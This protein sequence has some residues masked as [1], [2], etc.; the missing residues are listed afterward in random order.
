MNMKRI[1]VILMTAVTCLSFSSCWVIDQAREQKAEDNAAEE[2]VD[3]YEQVFAD[4]VRAAHGETASLTDVKC[5]MHES[6][7]MYYGLW[8]ARNDLLGT[9]ELNGNS[10]EAVYYC[11]TGKLRDSVHTEDICSEIT[12]ALP[13]DKSQIYE[14]VYPGY[15]YYDKNEY[16]KI[17]K[18]DSS[19][20]TLDDV[21][22]NGEVGK[23][24]VKVFIFTYEDVSSLT[25][26]EIM[27]LPI[28]AKFDRLRNYGNISI[29]SLKDTGALDDLKDKLNRNRDLI[30]QY[31]RDDI[32]DE[33]RQEFLDNFHL[34]CA[35]AVKNDFYYSNV[36]EDD[37]ELEYYKI[38]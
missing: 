3:K 12:N 7:R 31:K 18:F 17:L 6:G 9:I 8:E 5:V 38:G 24:D 19:L 32:T 28:I 33:K 21:I 22:A 25:E 1:M 26:A 27:S 36:G 35:I 2:L 34:N 13:L 15:D 20:N 14:V 10:Y 4:K 23:E 30:T 37:P 16:G 11:E 29:L